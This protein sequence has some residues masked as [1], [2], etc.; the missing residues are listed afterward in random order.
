M[1]QRSDLQAQLYTSRGKHGLARSANTGNVPTQQARDCQG[2]VRAQCEELT[3]CSLC[4]QRAVSK[5]PQRLGMPSWR[6]QRAHTAN[7]GLPGPGACLV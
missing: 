4:W 3:A 6:K 1:R 7:Q 2:Q 5:M